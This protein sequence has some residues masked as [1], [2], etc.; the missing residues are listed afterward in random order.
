MSRSTA[1]FGCLLK[2]VFARQPLR[3]RFPKR[4]ECRRWSRLPSGTKYYSCTLSQRYCAFYNT[5]VQNIHENSLSAM[6]HQCGIVDVCLASCF[7]YF[8]WAFDETWGYKH[9]NV[10][11]ESG[12]VCDWSGVRPNS[13]DMPNCVLGICGGHK[14]GDLLPFDIKV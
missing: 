14:Y 6:F 13:L 3:C 4:T 2:L 7:S 5:L 9:G 12:T 1:I 8:S 10:V 11:G